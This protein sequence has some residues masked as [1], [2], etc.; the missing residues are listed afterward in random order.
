VENERPSAQAKIPLK[1]ECV[2]K[3][4]LQK[5][6]AMLLALS[7]VMGLMSVTAFAEGEEAGEAPAE[8]V[9]QVVTVGG[10]NY[11][12]KKVTEPD[13]YL[14]GVLGESVTAE[15]MAE[16]NAAVALSKTIEA[17]DT[18]NIFDITLTVNTLLPQG[19]Q[20]TVPESPDSA[21]V[22][23]I[24]MSGTMHRNKMDGTRYVEVAKAEAKALVE[25]YAKNTVDFKYNDLVTGEEK[26]FESTAKRMVSVVVFDTDA[27]VQQNWVDVNANT[28]T[29]GANLAAVTAAINS[30]RVTNC[31]CGGNDPYYCKH[32]CTNF[33]GGLMLTR[34]LLNAKAVE[35]IVEDENDK[36]F[37]VILSDGAPT[38][39]VNDDVTT[40]GTIKASFWDA[41]NGQLTSA[42]EKYQKDGA[43]GGWTHPAE[44]E[45]NLDNLSDVA[46]L[47]TDKGVY[48]VGVGGLMNVKLFDEAVNSTANGGRDVLGGPKIYKNNDAFNH[49]DALQG[50]TASEIMKLTTGDWM[51]ILA[52]KVGGSYKSATSKTAM[53]E[54]FNG[55]FAEIQATLK[56]EDKG[57]AA[58]AWVVEDTMGATKS[59]K[60]IEFLE[61]IGGD[62]DAAE[63]NDNV[64]SWDLKEIDRDPVDGLYTYELKY[65]VRLTTELKDFVEAQAYNANLGASFSYQVIEEEL[66]DFGDPIT[67]AFPVPQVQGYLGEFSFVKTDGTGAIPEG[68]ENALFRLTHDEDCEICG[69][70]DSWVGTKD[71]FEA[72]P[73]AETGVVTFAGIPS[74]HTYTLTEKKTPDDELFAKDE[75]EYAVEVNFGD[76]TLA[77]WP[78]QPE[79]YKG[80][81][82]AFPNLKWNQLTIKKVVEV[83]NDSFHEEYG[84]KVEDRLE[85][86]SFSNTSYKFDII[87]SEDETVETVS[88]KPSDAEGVTVK[89]PADT[90][91]V[92]EQT[93]AEVKNYSWSVAYVPETAEF[94]LYDGTEADVTATNTY[95]FLSNCIEV[96]ADK[97]WEDDENRDG[98]RPAGLLF[99]LLIDGK[100]IAD[101][102]V[103]DSTRF[104]LEGK[105]ADDY[106]VVFKYSGNQHTGAPTV[107]EV[108][109][110]DDEGVQH[111]DETLPGYEVSY[112]DV[113]NVPGKDDKYKAP[114]TN[115]HEPELID[116]DVEK[117]WDE[118]YEDEEGYMEPVT[119]TLW[120]DNGEGKKPTK[121]AE[122]VL[123]VEETEEEETPAEGEAALTE[124]VP[125]EAPA[126]PEPE[127]GDE[128]EDI[129]S[130]TFTEDADGNPLYRYADGEEIVYYVT[131]DCKG[132]WISNIVEIENGAGEILGW[133]IENS[134]EKKDPPPKDKEKDKEKEKVTID[135]TTPP[136]VDIKD[137]E[138]PLEELVDN[139]IPLVPKTGDISALWL[140]LGALSG[141]G[142]AGVSILNRKKR[143]D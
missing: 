79:G 77:D 143:E 55:I 66:F 22:L 124:E 41:T 29:N 45:D 56:L 59:F 57:A 61:F 68:V 51:K 23:T 62:D 118:T 72:S 44:V 73:A 131:E 6:F 76:V 128:E 33:D 100:S 2:M 74:G 12:E 71:Y 125:G 4:K 1:G 127:E 64:I 111:L 75:N 140:A 84:D 42:G 39:S 8:T 63:E 119:V 80:E 26:D 21:L 69:G 137:P 97:I 117:T 94:E 139:P 126:D 110:V 122:T 60:C 10:T 48:I 112:G 47:T 67:V 141:T 49:V 105:E 120:I 142:L 28:D 86:D 123:G 96:T 106:V 19:A 5:L 24:D 88:V 40:V 7:L 27:R 58:D 35:D 103:A 133:S 32:V 82:P 70:S 121:V 135:D 16:N 53:T 20:V 37:A 95:V 87:N 114:V 91:T 101:P 104:I 50:Y 17:T 83:N 46:D 13:P 113:V 134:M 3:K 109:Y 136:L 99:E 38:V 25:K 115:T 31:T 85:V 30:I 108:G 52:D 18:E 132:E 92:V 11:F 54:V 98:I 9:N 36:S 138:I 89:L 34:N 14:P 102:A 129:W 65:S 116:L 43:G 78:E 107:V 81:D 15:T 90:Y 130:Y 93:P